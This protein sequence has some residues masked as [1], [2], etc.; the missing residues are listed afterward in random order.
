MFADCFTKFAKQKAGI[1]LTVALQTG[2]ARR[3]A[4]PLAR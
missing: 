4:Q 1:G 3:G 2:R